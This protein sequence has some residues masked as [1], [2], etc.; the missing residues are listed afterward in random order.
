MALASSCGHQDVARLEET[1]HILPSLLT[2]MGVLLEFQP[3]IRFPYLS[4]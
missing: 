1:E 4:G 3:Q 2:L